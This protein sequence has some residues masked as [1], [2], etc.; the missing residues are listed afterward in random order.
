MK[1]KNSKQRKAVMTKIRSIPSYVQT[2]VVL[3]KKLKEQEELTKKH[4]QAHDLAITRKRVSEL[5]KQASAEEEHAKL[6][7]Q[8]RELL[9]KEKKAL[10]HLTKEKHRLEHPN[11]YKAGKVLKKG[12]ENANGNLSRAGKWFNKN[13]EFK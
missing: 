12:A 1:F 5:R 6:L 11:F 8:E 9:S 4:K 7:K 3:R 10:S 13:F 2:Q